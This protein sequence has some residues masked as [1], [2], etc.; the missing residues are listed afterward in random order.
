MFWLKNFTTF[1]KMFG[2]TKN[3]TIFKNVCVCRRSFVRSLTR[4]LFFGVFFLMFKFLP[5][6]SSFSCA[7]EV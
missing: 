1:Q 7:L 4:T 2:I 6:F 3:V 5:L